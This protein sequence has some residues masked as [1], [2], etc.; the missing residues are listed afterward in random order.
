MQHKRGRYVLCDVYRCWEE[1]GETMWHVAWRLAAYVQIRM[2]VE[3]D[4]A[5]GLYHR[6]TDIVC[7][8]NGFHCELTCIRPLQKSKVADVH[9]SSTFGGGSSGHHVQCALIVDAES[10]GVVL[11]KAEIL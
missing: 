1:N 8:R 5:G 3:L 11:F 4:S 9:V 2:L 6:I 10:G 7:R